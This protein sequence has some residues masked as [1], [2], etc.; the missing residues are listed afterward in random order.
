MKILFY[1]Y[2]R[3]S[4]HFLSKHLLS[5]LPVTLEIKRSLP[6]FGKGSLIIFYY[7]AAAALLKLSESLTMVYG[8]YSPYA[9][10]LLTVTSCI[11]FPSLPLFPFLAQQDLAHASFCKLCCL[12]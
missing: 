2:F 9:D 7:K 10:S 4:V 12:P 8:S 3:Y 5:S 6:L 11:L 1:L